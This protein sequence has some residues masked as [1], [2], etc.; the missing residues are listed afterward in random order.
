VYLVERSSI[1][2][3]KFAALEKA[4]LKKRRPSLA[5]LLYP[6]PP[7]NKKVILNGI[8]FELKPGESLLGFRHRQ[9]HAWRAY[10]SDPSFQPQAAY[11]ST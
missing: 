8:S 4:A 5:P 9:N 7:P 3:P 6:V 1:S 10:W 2:E 11:V